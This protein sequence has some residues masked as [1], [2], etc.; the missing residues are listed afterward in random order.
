MRID[1]TASCFLAF[2]GLF[3]L[4]LASPRVSKNVLRRTSETF[5]IKPKVF[6]VDM[7]CSSCIMLSDLIT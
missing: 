1:T 6:I 2:C 7:V 4:G 3:E 5:V